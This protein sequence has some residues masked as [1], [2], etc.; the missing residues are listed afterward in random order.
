MR[1]PRSG[2]VGA[3]RSEMSHPEFFVGVDVVICRRRRRRGFPDRAIPNA[4]FE[5]AGRA[6]GGVK[7]R[8]K[9]LFSVR[10]RAKNR[11]AIRR[12]VRAYRELR[13]LWHVPHLNA[14]R[15]MRNAECPFLLD[16]ALRT[17]HSALEMWHVPHFSLRSFS[18][19]SALKISAARPSRRQMLNFNFVRKKRL[20]EAACFQLYCRHSTGRYAA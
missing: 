5:V 4:I 16:S 8:F 14:E 2:G 19:F 10:L 17:P 3:H 11:A 20:R 18:Y 6:T 9:M 7:A 13:E 15:G 12:L 1:R